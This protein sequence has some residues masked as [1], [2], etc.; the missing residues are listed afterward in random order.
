MA[1]VAKRQI[2]FIRRHELRARVIYRAT[3]SSQ[4]GVPERVER[5]GR[6]VV[7][8]VHVDGMG[9]NFEHDALGDALAVGESD[10]FEDAAV[11]GCCRG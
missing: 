4:I 8:C 1:A 11:K 2:C 9:G 10:I 6:G 5:G 3:A 7:R